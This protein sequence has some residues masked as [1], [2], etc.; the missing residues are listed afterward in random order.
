LA[1]NAVSIS[2]VSCNGGSNGA[3]NLSANGGT[4]PYSFLWNIG[5]TSEDLLNL[6]SG[7]YSCVVTDAN[8]CIDSVNQTISQPFAPLNSFATINQQVNCFGGSDASVDLSVSGGTAPY[9]YSW[10]NGSSNQDLS[11]LSAGIYG[12]LII[13]ANGC[14]DSASVSI[15]Q[16]QAALALAYSSTVP[17][18]CSGGNNG[19]I[20]LSVTGGTSPYFYQWSNGSANEDLTGLSSGTYAVF[21]IDAN[22]CSDSLSVFIGQPQ[23]NLAV[24]ANSVSNVDCFGNT[25]GSI[26]L[27]VGGGTAPY[28]YQWNN[29][30]VSEDLLSI[31]A[32]IYTVSVL[33]ANGCYGSISITVNE[34]SNPLASTATVTQQVNCFAGNDGSIDLSVSGGTAPY[35]YLWSNGSNSEDLNGL[36]SGT[37][38]VIITD[39]NGCN[40]SSFLFVGQPQ[41]SLSLNAASTTDVDCFGNS[42]GSID[43]AVTDGTAPYAYQ[44]SNGSSNE[45]IS[46]LS[47]GTYT[48]LV[49][50]ANGCSDSL[51]LV[52][53]Q[54]QAALAVSA[55]SVS[56][57][58]CFGN[59]TGSIDL[60]VGGGTA[61]YNYLWSDGSV[62][63]DLQF[64]SAGTYVVSVVDANGC[65]AT[66]SV[67]VNEPANPL[68]SSASVTQQVN[69]FAGNDGSIDLTVT[70]GTAPYGFSW[71]NGSVDE[72]L[73]GL[74]A[75]TYS[76]I[77]IDS[78][79]CSD[80]AIVV[81]VQPQAAL[82]LSTVSTSDVDCFGNSNGS[83]DLSVSGGTVPYSYQWSNGSNSE[84]LNGIPSGIY[85][86]LVLDANGCLDSLS[87][88][89]TQPADSL[90][91]AIT[92]V[93]D[94]DCYGSSTGSIDLGVSGGTQPYSYS[95]SNGDV[96]Q[97]LNGVG[98][99]TYTVTVVDI[100]GCQST[101]TIGV[102]EPINPI[103]NSINVSQEV[104]CFNG[105][106]GA[107]D[108][109]VSG[110]TSPYSYA[111]SNGATTQNITNLSSGNYSVLIIDANGCVDSATAFVNQPQDSLSLAV[112][113]IQQVN[114]FGGNDGSIDL[115][116]TGGTNPYAFQ[117][118][119]GSITEDISNIVAGTYTVTITDANGCT[120][121][122]SVVINQPAEELV[123]QQT[124]V[125]DVLCFGGDDASIDLTIT[126]GTL[127]YSFV[128]SNGASSEDLTGI[129][130]GAYS[131][132]VTDLNGCTIAQNFQI[133][134]PSAALSV[135]GATLVGDCINNIGGDINITP[136]GGTAPYSYLWNTGA[137]SQNL[138]N[139]PSA[140]YS[141]TV[142]D[143]NGC[144][145][146][147]DF[148]LAN[149]AYV[150]VQITDPEI[151]VGDSALLK[152]NVNVPATYQWYYNNTP[153]QG[154]VNDEYQAYVQGFYKCEVNSVCGVVMSDS[155]DVTVRSLTGASI[156]S[157]QI[158]CPP[159]SVELVATG[160]VNYEWSPTIYIS[161]PNASNP[162]VN[163]REST[164]YTVLVTDDFGCKMSMSVDITVV[165]DTMLIPTGFSPNDDG[166]NDGYEIEGIENYP[167]NIL[168]IYNRWGNLIY[169]A[170]DYKNNWTGECNVSGIQ[171][172]QKLPSGTYYYILDL[173]DGQKPRNG[174]IILRR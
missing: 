41:A 171:F 56:N 110:G 120:N 133:T 90:A 28:A 49:T 25:T 34:P 104:N 140:A 149:S 74:S 16:P 126:G 7:T 47:S 27:S 97:D 173:N 168:Y 22:G 96:T 156:S 154:A 66:L 14:Q 98:A 10:S 15:S 139:Q 32:G 38:S 53:G 2:D 141:V 108:L 124:S 54:P 121:T 103:S 65:D 63:E 116:T 148:V 43:L 69:C 62:T 44:W 87:A 6:A 80:S 78:N 152:V 81:I 77:I 119:N 162:V 59:S 12:V 21:V 145:T 130:A 89:I 161:D 4:G 20:D 67:T 36:S 163:P 122:L 68:A 5:S 58:D 46:G 86:V 71:S 153:I 51:S 37:Y 79:G 142:T 147:T 102:G 107:I 132:T 92:S 114:C 19:A 134:Q 33:D 18:S 13:D 150:Y 42:T 160:G 146:T 61:P 144:T 115:N 131:V 75:G 123:I 30:S 57:V 136:A 72:D 64:I 84:D 174:Y 76:V 157:N 95:W 99:G 8:G 9:S 167:G 48:V 60:S 26:D 23:A 129:G 11:G 170:K 100:N 127:P 125:Q 35:T 138:N 52:I 88:N 101:I 85:T 164:T 45:D 50:D 3:I 118:S 111:W 29:G 117:W 24:S 158:L 83:I 169:K 70:G 109:N 112:G 31:P 17:V 135:S 1:V 91:L 105:N 39:A 40:D 143:A 93:S 165:C 82:A 113:V 159:E 166:V 155:V 172:G 106:D 137:T 94:V 73:N 151:C 55:N 128:W